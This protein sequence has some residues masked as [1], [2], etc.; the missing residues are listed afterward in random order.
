MQDPHW[1]ISQFGY[2]PSYVIGRAF[3]SQLHKSLCKNIDLATSIKK[4]D[5]THPVNWLKQNIFSHGMSKSPKDILISSTNEDFN[6]K[7]YID[8]LS[9]E[10]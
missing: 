10:R 5:L 4:E 9:S 8:E 1:F 2:F 7:Y 3:A 6:P